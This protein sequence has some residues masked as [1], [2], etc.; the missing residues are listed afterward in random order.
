MSGRLET[1]VAEAQYKQ[2][3]REKNF[4]SFRLPGRLQLKKIEWPVLSAGTVKQL[5]TKSAPGPDGITPRLLRE[6]VHEEAVQ[7]GV[8]FT[9]SMSSGVV[10]EDW[11]KAHVTAIYIQK[12]PK[13]KPVEL[14]PYFP[15]LCAWQGDGE[16]H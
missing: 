1:F 7:L 16:D 13:I 6:L 3:H 10:P 11:R 4:K 2:G 14:S 12:R 5:K 9:K 8:I 15:D